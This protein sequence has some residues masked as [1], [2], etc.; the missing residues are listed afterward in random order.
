[1]RR[2]WVQLALIFIGVALLTASGLLII[3]S[4][5]NNDAPPS[6][7]RAITSD[8]GLKNQLIALYESGITLEQSVGVLLLVDTVTDGRVWRFRL[9]DA[10]GNIVFDN[11]E[12]ITDRPIPDGDTETP[13]SVN[14]SNSRPPRPISGSGANRPP[15]PPNAPDNSGSAPSISNTDAL[16]RD[17]VG[18][19]ALRIREDVLDL[20]EYG[21]LT[22]LRRTPFLRSPRD[23]E[24]D[25]PLSAFHLDTISSLILLVGGLIGIIV[26]IVLS[27]YLTRPLRR[28]TQGASEFAGRNFG[29][30]VQ[31]SGSQ[32]Y[33]Q[34]A[35]AMNR[36]A[37]EL[38]ESDRLRKNLV[39]D[40]AHELR[41]P[42]SVLEGS[43]RA[44]I[45]DVYP[46]EKS[47]IMH[48]YDQTR[49]LHRLVNDL[50]EL[51]LADAKRLPLNKQ[52][53]DVQK[54]VHSVVDIF[55][56]IAEST[57]LDVNVKF[58]GDLKP[59]TIDEFR[60]T[61]VIHNL[62]VNALHH[63][64]AD[65]LISV[66]TVGTDN[67]IRINVHD[68]G[69]GIPADDL[70]Y[71]FER[72]YRADKSRTRER[73]G[74]GLGLAISK[75]IIEAHDGTITAESSTGTDR[76]TTFFIVLPYTQTPAS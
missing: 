52:P 70:P 66:Q 36:M 72:F 68:T 8:T 31:P 33:Q 11:L 24:P 46:L 44:I 49:L 34:V 76:G 12:S 51:T 10:D 75:A 6:P 25:D 21:Q 14:A 35:V 69:E 64:P 2:L 9:Q 56:P 39:A 19:P 67:D 22:I 62:L 27:L 61:Q 1:M 54:L 23:R 50:H 73:G 20:G 15:R 60:I 13:T 45:D 29:Y 57:G 4:S 47:E 53:T 59:I 41:T 5:I 48:I 17:L 55:K 37:E 3:S 40:I 38:E 26:A 7:E 71:I 58:E 42:L 28:L 63:T 74:T 18:N 43:T 16:L 32:E 65:G 30:R